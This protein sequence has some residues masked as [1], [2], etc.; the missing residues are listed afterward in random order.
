MLS[1]ALLLPIDPGSPL[2]AQ[3]ALGRGLPGRFPTAAAD[4]PQGL[5]VLQDSESSSN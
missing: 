4:P 5:E 2:P 1:Q 3:P